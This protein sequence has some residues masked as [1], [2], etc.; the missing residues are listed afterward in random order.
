MKKIKQPY[1]KPHIEVLRINAYQLLEGVSIDPE[2]NL[3]PI[4]VDPEEEGAA[5]FNNLYSIWEN[6]EDPS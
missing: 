6:W 4:E 3:D 1:A 5:R 2:N